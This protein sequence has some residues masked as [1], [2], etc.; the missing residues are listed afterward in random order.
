MFY[1]S[2]FTVDSTGFERPNVPWRREMVSFEAIDTAAT[3]RFK[4]L[5]NGAANITLDNVCVGL[6]PVAIQALSRGGL[7]LLTGLVMGTAV[8]LIRRRRLASP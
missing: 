4:A 8:W 1:L 7:A 3:L 6:A 5:T 2:A